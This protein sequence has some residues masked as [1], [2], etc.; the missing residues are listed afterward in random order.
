MK[1]SEKS[2]P[3]LH[4][5][6]LLIGVVVVWSCNLLLFLISDLMFD[7]LLNLTMMIVGI[8]FLLGA[9]GLAYVHG[10]FKKSKTWKIYSVFS[11]VMWAV[12]YLL[13]LSRLIW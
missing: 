10:I 3:G 4:V 13:Y 6:L 11:G 1:I 9:S 12:V 5:I 8:H 2:L 7:S